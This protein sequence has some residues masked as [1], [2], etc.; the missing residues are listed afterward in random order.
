MHILL[1][2]SLRFASWKFYSRRSYSFNPSPAYSINLRSYIIYWIHIKTTNN[3]F[4][5]LFEIL[6]FVYFW[7]SFKSSFYRRY[8]FTSPTSPSP[9]IFIMRELLSISN[10][11][12]EAI[13]NIWFS[14]INIVKRM[15][16][17]FH[18][19][20]KEAYD[21]VDGTNLH[22]QRMQRMQIQ[23][24]SWTS[25][26]WRQWSYQQCLSLQMRLS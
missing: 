21:W 13:D 4:F 12:K 2:S 11:Y 1:L 25:P 18:T 24:Q 6:L 26:R 22:L 3:S 14:C 19:V 23:M 10:Y 9:G 20:L 8:A 7:I 15:L 16:Q 17:Y 5:F